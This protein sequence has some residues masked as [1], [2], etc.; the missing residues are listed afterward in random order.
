MVPTIFACQR[1]PSMAALSRTDA[2]RSMRVGAIFC[3]M[4][5]LSTCT[6]PRRF[7]AG[8][9]VMSDALTVVTYDGF[10]ALVL[11]VVSLSAVETP[12]WQ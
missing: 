12:S 2:S 6:A 4:T 3:Q 9:F 7:R 10:F 11:S 1:V 5:H 8:I